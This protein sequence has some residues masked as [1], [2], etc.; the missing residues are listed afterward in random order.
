MAI[1]IERCTFEEVLPIWRDQLWPERKSAIEAYSPLRCDGGYDTQY[2]KSEVIFLCAKSANS[3][4]SSAAM[5]GVISG[6]PTAPKEFRVRGAWVDPQYRGQGWGHRLLRQLAQHAEHQGAQIIWTLPRPT[7]LA[8]YEKNGFQKKSDW[9]P[10]F[11]FGPNCVAVCDLAK[12]IQPV[13]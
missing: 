2:A 4:A 7:N 11:E 9:M 13:I 5:I 3:E 10:G 12:R 1:T 8:F 6:F